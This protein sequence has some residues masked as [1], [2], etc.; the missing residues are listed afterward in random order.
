MLKTEVQSSTGLEAIQEPLL[1]WAQDDLEQRLGFRGGRFTSCNK[2][3]TFLA[4]IL[5]GALFYLFVVYCLKPFPQTAFVAHMFLEHGLIPYPIVGLFFWAMAILTV[6]WRKLAYQRRALNL[7]AV[8]QEPD[9]VLD[10]RT[11][12]E[13]LKRIRTLVDDTRNFILLNRIEH[14]LSNLR[15]I[16]NISEA[17][18]ILRTQAQYDEEQVASSY[19]MVSGFV[20]AT[21]VLG[22]IGT[23][24]GLSLAIGGFG[25]A[26]EASGDLSAIKDSLRGTTAGLSTAFE[27]TLVALVATLI[28]QLYM[29]HLQH[30]EAKFLD[31]CSDYCHTN[32]VSK[33]RLTDN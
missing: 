13:V 5:M 8:P 18:N 22:F 33:L 26:L 2:L 24:L 1:N 3:L 21:P 25:A 28:I 23:V 14:A 32:L 31:E 15:N 30:E 6:K 10:R 4:A 29:T 11:A 12:A 27:T 9:F 20:W 16:G 17:A 7:A 19:K